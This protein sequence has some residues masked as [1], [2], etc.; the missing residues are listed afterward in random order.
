MIQWSMLTISIL[1]TCEREYPFMVTEAHIRPSSVGLGYES[2]I[3]QHSGAIPEE[4]KG[5]P[6]YSEVIQELFYK[7]LLN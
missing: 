1:L 7:C 5:C 3:T 2:A 6:I 4:R